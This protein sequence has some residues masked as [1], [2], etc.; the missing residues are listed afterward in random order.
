MNAEAFSFSAKEKRNWASCPNFATGLVRYPGGPPPAKAVQGLE[1]DDRKRF[2]VLPNLAHLSLPSSLS[3]R[4]EQLK[5]TKEEFHHTRA[6]HRFT[7]HCPLPT[8]NCPLPTAHCQL[9]TAH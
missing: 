7:A 8:A 6:Q 1:P 2:G 3:R 9:P 4:S 5:A